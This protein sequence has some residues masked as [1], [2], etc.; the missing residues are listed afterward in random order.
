M[1]GGKTDL[2]SP[3]RTNER[4]TLTRKRQIFRNLCA[5]YSNMAK[6]QR[7]AF[8]LAKNQNDLDKR[9][10]KI[11]DSYQ[12]QIIDNLLQLGDLI[13]LTQAGGRPSNEHVNLGYQVL[14]KHYIATGEILKPKQL[15]KQVC[16]EL[17]MTGY[18]SKNPE[19]DPFS[20]S[21]ASEVITLF[22]ICLPHENFYKN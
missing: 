12:N 20:I 7:K 4:G 9:R 8:D 1:A 11:Y 21:R 2:L 14:T 16:S 5:T 6:E 18:K 17:V 13:D 22:K 10:L 15:S 3:P 19:R